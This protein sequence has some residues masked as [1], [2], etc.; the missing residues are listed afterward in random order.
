MRFGIFFQ[1][2]GSGMTSWHLTWS[3]AT[4]GWCCLATC[5]PRCQDALEVTWVILFLCRRFGTSGVRTS[6][7][8]GKFAHGGGAV[9]RGKSAL[10]RESTGRQWRLLPPGHSGRNARARHRHIP[11]QRNPF[12]R[13]GENEFFCRYKFRLSN[14]V[15]RNFNPESNRFC[16][17]LICLCSYQPIATTV[18]HNKFLL[19]FPISQII[20]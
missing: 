10:Y 18:E 8:C 9:D 20:V 7:F 2:Q 3:F 6:K 14:F 19:T 16:N 4:G 13:W 11:I 5:V 15:S 12:N 1:N 17:L